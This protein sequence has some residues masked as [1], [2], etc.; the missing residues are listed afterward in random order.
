MKTAEDF[1]D[2]KVKECTSYPY[3]DFHLKKTLV[4]EVME[5]YASYKEIKP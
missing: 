5:E 4:L 2:D 1:Y 3:S